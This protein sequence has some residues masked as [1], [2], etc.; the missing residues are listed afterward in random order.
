MNK[1]KHIII[2]ILSFSISTKAQEKYLFKI[3]E[4]D[5]E[6]RI[7]IPVRNYFYISKIIDERNGDTSRIG[8]VYKRFASNLKQ[9]EATFQNGLVPSFGIL[10]KMGG[11]SEK[12]KDIQEPFV[13]SIKDLEITE[14]IGQFKSTGRVDLT[15]TFFKKQDDI[16]VPVFTTEVF[17]E[18]GMGSIKSNLVKMK[19]CLEK[20]LIKLEDFLTNKNQPDFYSANDKETQDEAEK[21]GLKVQIYE[22]NDSEKVSLMAPRKYGIYKSFN[23]FMKNQPEIIGNFTIEYVG[24]NKPILNIYSSSKKRLKGHYFCLYDGQNIYMNSQKTSG[25]KYFVKVSTIGNLIAW[26][27][28]TIK[29]MARQATYTGIGAGLGGGLGA[30]LGS[31]IAG[32]TSYLDCIALDVRTGSITILE[33]RDM[34]KLLSEDI[35][36]LNAY[37]SA[38]NPKDGE[39]LLYYVK[40]YNKQHPLE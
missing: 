25:Y 7:D 34:E 9:M 26:K 15:V 17:E 30:A 13:I 40:E 2:I 16:F 33:P 10:I 5:S 14:T 11:V 6:L 21:F 24:L 23:S 20:S 18:A 28:N 35:Q 31:T 4:K 32:S 29:S 8:F 19:K 37:K 12:T 3:D 38:P 27:D 22:K 1:I 39:V 36:L